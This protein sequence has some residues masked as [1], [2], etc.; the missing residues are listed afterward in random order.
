[1]RRHVLAA[2]LAAA[3]SLFACA[4]DPGELPSSDAD[5]RGSVAS[6]LVPSAT[7]VTIVGRKLVLDGHDYQVRGVDYSPIPIGGDNSS[8]WGPG[9]LDGHGG[10]IFAEPAYQEVLAKDV[11]QMREMGVNTIRIYAMHPWD[12]QKGPRAMRSHTKFLDMLWNGGDRPIRAY[13]A[14]P[15]SPGIFRYTRVSAPPTDGSFF[16]TT[17]EGDTFVADEARTEAGWAWNGQQT[18]A[19]RRATDK[20]AFEA[21][22]EEVGSHP[23]VLGF[24][25]SNE[26]NL[27]Q[28]RQNPA[29]W[30]YMNELGAAV[31]A[32]APKK[33]TLMALIDDSMQSLR[34]VKQKGFDVSNIDVFGVN[35]YRGRLDPNASTNDFDH[36]FEELAD[37]SEK[38]FVVTEFGAPATTRKEILSS[39]GAPVRPGSSPSLV[40]MCPNG[41]MVELPDRAKAQA[42]YIEGHWKHID[43][44]RDVVAGGLVFEWQ[45]EY[46]KAGAH[47]NAIETDV[48]HATPSKAASE[49]FPGGCWDEEGFGIHAVENRRGGAYFPGPGVQVVDGRTPRA[50]FD[51]LKVLWAKP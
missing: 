50:A 49:A 46:F 20:R 22:A 36:L 25:L 31:K 35:S 47:A 1:M 19:E 13:V 4:H 48:W 34:I 44:N 41:A 8:F 33:H 37:V 26:L 38:P 30:A 21:L 5:G 39:L 51:R 12:A 29:F 45:D 10:D 42:D 32:R 40:S 17:P 14:F 3:T 7:D 18:A 24:V 9:N 28:N 11:A 23:A 6:A 27:V 43:A 2:L 15:V 16:V